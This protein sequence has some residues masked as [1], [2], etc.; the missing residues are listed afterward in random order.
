MST[1]QSPRNCWTLPDTRMNDFNCI[2]T[3]VFVVINNFFNFLLSASL[4]PLF[5]RTISGSSWI[6]RFVN[7]NLSLFIVGVRLLVSL[8]VSFSPKRICINVGSLTCNARSV[9]CTRGLVHRASRVDSRIS[10][11]SSLEPM[12]GLAVN[13]SMCGTEFPCFFAGQ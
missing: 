11:L 3:K 1:A 2:C 10:R 8:S 12:T 9:F 4:F 5:K 13:P 6:L 7:A